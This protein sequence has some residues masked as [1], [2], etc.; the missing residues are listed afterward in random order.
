VIKSGSKGKG[1][2]FLS[3]LVGYARNMYYPLIKGNRSGL[4]PDGYMERNASLSLPLR[5]EVSRVVIRS[6]LSA[7]TPFAIPSINVPYGAITTD[8]GLASL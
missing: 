5:S 8:E 6:R 7:R 2:P 1:N 4:Y 3:R